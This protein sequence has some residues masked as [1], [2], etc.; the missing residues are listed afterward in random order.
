ME[1][2]FGMLSKLSW[3]MFVFTHYIK[4]IR[5]AAADTEAMVPKSYAENVIPEIV[6]LPPGNSCAIGTKR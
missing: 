1:K 2:A 6:L 5:L 4:L 3:A